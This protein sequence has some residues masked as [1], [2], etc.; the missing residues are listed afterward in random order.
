MTPMHL[1][2]VEA[3]LIGATVGALASF[4]GTWF[5]QRATLARERENRIWERRATVYE[6]A[7]TSVNRGER[8]RA[9][10]LATGDLP[11]V[12][13]QRGREVEADLVLARLRIYG[14]PRVVDAHVRTVAAMTRWITHFAAWKE[15]AAHGTTPVRAQTDPLWA[16]VLQEAERASGVEQQFVSIVQAEIQAEEAVRPLRSRVPWRRRRS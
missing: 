15:Q 16:A 1:T 9:G 13:E 2:P 10:V 4:G 7:L 5:I 14:S 6:E 11:R 8:F 3:T 12:P